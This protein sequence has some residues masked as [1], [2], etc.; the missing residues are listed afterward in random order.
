MQLPPLG[1]RVADVLRF[2]RARVQRLHERLDGAA[3]GYAKLD[4]RV[5]F[6]EELAVAEELETGK[7]LSSAQRAHGK[8]GGQYLYKV[9]SPR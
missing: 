6:S 1:N 8:G 5:F 4:Y 2:L 7:V 3:H 9:Q